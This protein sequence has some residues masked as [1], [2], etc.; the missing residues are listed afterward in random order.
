M[1]SVKRWSLSLLVTLALVV[2]ARVLFGGQDSPQE[3]IVP[4]ALSS[5]IEED[6]ALQAEMDT[7]LERGRV[8]QAI[9]AE[10]LA[11]RL[12]LRQAAARFQAAGASKPEAVLTQWRKT[13]PGDTDEERYCWNVLRHVCV[14]VRNEPE[15]ARA[16]RQRLEMELP[17]HLRYRLP[18]S[19]DVP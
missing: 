17:D 5:L 8:Q 12:T 2:G 18:S 4:G 10:V 7:C 11:G 1:S 6:R 16:V 15:Q 14:R 19:F 9:V 13:C 3:L